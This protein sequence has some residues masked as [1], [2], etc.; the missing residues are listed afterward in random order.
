MQSPEDWARKLE[1]ALGRPLRVRYSRSRRVPVQ[2]AR[3]RPGSRESPEL[4]LHG[5]IFAAADEQVVDCLSLWVDCALSGQRQREST[6]RDLAAFIDR[7]LSA[8]P[9]SV[10]RVTLDARGEHHDLEALA[11]RVQAQDF[12]LEF[13]DADARPLLSWGRRGKS[14]CRHSLRLGSYHSQSRLI[15]VHSVL[16]QAAVPDWFVAFILFHELLH[17]ALPAERD[18][19]GRRAH[20]SNAFRQRE[21]AHRDYARARAWER[22]HIRALIRSARA[23]SPF[24]G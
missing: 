17:A 20:H 1:G 22:Q 15:R 3:P 2:L 14:R 6:R 12:P 19:T 24:R 5:G 10:R 23:G 8:L 18:A 11:R 9:V 13:A 7:Q 21:A 16:D 4:R